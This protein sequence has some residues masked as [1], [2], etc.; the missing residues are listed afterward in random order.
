MACL[1]AATASA[2]FETLFN[3]STRKKA[4][5]S[6]ANSSHEAHASLPQNRRCASL[7]TTLEIASNCE[8]RPE[9]SPPREEGF[10]RKSQGRESQA[11]RP[12]ACGRV[13]K[14]GRRVSC[15]TSV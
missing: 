12:N 4:G 5:K 1:A 10:A 15:K 14:H 2:S 9:S 13:R 6:W 11:F 8:K 7:A 3:R